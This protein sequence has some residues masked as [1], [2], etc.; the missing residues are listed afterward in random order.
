MY[1]YC[2]TCKKKYPLNSHSYRCT[3]GGMFRLHKDQSDELTREI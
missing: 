1:F 2:E 3:C